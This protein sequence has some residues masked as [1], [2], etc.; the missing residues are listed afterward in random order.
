MK[1]TINDIADAREGLLAAGLGQ[2]L[3]QVGIEFEIEDTPLV[4][5]RK[6]MAQQ[7]VIEAPA[8]SRTGVVRV[9]MPASVKITRQSVPAPATLAASSDDKPRVTIRQRILDCIRDRPRTSAEGERARGLDVNVLQHL[10]LAK[11]DGLAVKD[12]ETEIWS[13]A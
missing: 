11:R 12:S 8:A 10:Y 13:L 3:E 9:K 1:V 6:L 7:P 5:S 2:W 4:V